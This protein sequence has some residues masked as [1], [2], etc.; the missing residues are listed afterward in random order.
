MG[1]YSFSFSSSRNITT[2]AYLL[3][4]INIHVYSRIVVQG[5][6]VSHHVHNMPINYTVD[7]EFILTN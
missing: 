4:S 2:I 6:R 3:I 5:M 1:K 7:N